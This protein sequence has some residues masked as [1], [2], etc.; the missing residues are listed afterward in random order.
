MN[1]KFLLAF[2]GTN[3]VVSRL[4]ERF[5]CISPCDVSKV[6]STKLSCSFSCMDV[7]YTLFI[8]QIVYYHSNTNLSSALVPVHGWWAGLAITIESWGSSFR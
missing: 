2:S 5:A 3:L 8:P 7:K 1:D 4:I 6:T